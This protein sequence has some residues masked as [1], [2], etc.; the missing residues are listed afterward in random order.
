[1]YIPDQAAFNRP[2]SPASFWLGWNK[3]REAQFMRNALQTGTGSARPSKV[4]VDVRLTR[5]RSAE[6]RDP[7]K[8]RW[9]VEYSITFEVPDAA[10]P[11]QTRRDPYCARALWDFEGASRNLFTLERWEDLEPLA[12]PQNPCPGSLGTLGIL[13][14]D[15]RT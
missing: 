9:E 2:P 5:D 10:H 3:E 4:E 12:N 8:R 1:M 15:F 14:G 6:L 7:D 13:R 11:G